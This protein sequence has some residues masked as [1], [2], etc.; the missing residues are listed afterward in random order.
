MRLRYF[1]IALTV[2]ILSSVQPAS[3][4]EVEMMSMIQ[5]LQKQM[6][7]MQSVID[8]QGQRLSLLEKREASI[9]IAGQDA[10]QEKVVAPMS[11]KEFGGHLNKSL[12][13]A[14]TWLKGLVFKADS[15]LRYE[16]FDYSSGSPNNTP[17]RNRFRMRL[18]FG[19]EKTFSPEFKVGFSLGTGENVTTN[20]L[21]ANPAS[22]NQTMNNDFNFKSIWV[23]KIFAT[24]TPEWAKVGPIAAMNITAGKFDNP[25]ERGSTDMIWSTTVKPE[26]IYEMADLDLYK[27]ESVKVKAYTT[28][29]Q[30]V[31]RETGAYTSASTGAQKD[32]ELFAYQV[33]L[34]PS[35][36]TG[37]MEKPI[38][39][40]S[41]LSFYSYPGYAKYSNWRLGGLAGQSLASGNPISQGNATQLDAA[42]FNVLSVYQEAA[43]FPHGIPV[44][45]FGEWA[46]NL[47]ANPNSLGIH[48]AA[49]SWSLGLKLGK[50]Q[51]KGDME[52]SYAYKWIGAN[53]VVG[54][55]N[56]NDFGSGSYGGAGRRGSAIRL[57]YGLTDYLRLNGGV[58][59]VN[60][61]N[62]GYFNLNNGTILDEEIRRFQVDLNWK[63]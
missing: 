5:N 55:F 30:F 4:G 34:N 28:L 59:L 37:L 36:K 31:L 22:Q 7:R 3:A 32:A 50:V 6:M 54:V 17:D 62:T 25:F 49:N 51:R 44:R 39:S 41:T 38:E 60:A 13:G 26:G 48:D 35:F 10:R 43:F 56:D 18:R 52:A 47:S 2:F 21:Q 14:E 23:E 29:G 27:G 46:D 33:G 42:N 53:S 12:S 40:L 58:F 9:Q 57:G 61:L 20:G 15:R 8:S 63:F 24:Y 19:F 45:P 11:E 1:V 16:A